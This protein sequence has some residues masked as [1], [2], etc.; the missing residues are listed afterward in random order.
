MAAH[1]PGVSHAIAVEPDCMHKNFGAVWF[2]V[3]AFVV[4]LFLTAFGLVVHILPR[5]NAFG[6]TMRL[7]SKI[8]EMSN[9]YG[10][11]LHKLLFSPTLL[12]CSIAVPSSASPS[13]VADLAD[14]TLAT[15]ETGRL[16][17]WNLCE[18]SVGVTGSYFSA[19]TVDDILT[20]IVADFAG[21]GTENTNLIPE[22]MQVGFQQVSVSQRGS[23]VFFFLFVKTPYCE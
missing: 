20:H 7:A 13:S 17:E 15:L 19:T 6:T 23:V 2:A 1:D 21:G 3:F 8:T 5:V 12:N 9:K 10:S 4:P 16:A 11:L 22:K 18:I 14:C